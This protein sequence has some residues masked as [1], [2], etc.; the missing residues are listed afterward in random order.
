MTQPNI[1]IQGTVTG[2]FAGLSEKDIL[3]HIEGGE[4]VE[5]RRFRSREGDG[6][7]P[8]VLVTFKETQLPGRVF[9][10]AMAFQV[11]EYI[12]PPLRCYNC[13]RYGHIA[14]ACRGKKKCA[15][16]GGEHE[17]KECKADAPKCPNCGGDHKAAYWGCEHTKKARKVQEV[18]ERDKVTYAE[19]VRK[20]TRECV[21]K[22]RGRGPPTGNM[23]AEPS[24]C[25]TVP[26]DMLIMSKESFLSFVVEVLAA[27][28][29]VFARETS[30]NSD[31]VREVVGAADRFLG[32]KQVPEELHE[33]FSEGRRREQRQREQHD[34]E[35]DITDDVES[36]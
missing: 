12:R 32:V 11:R 4:V 13:Q 36:D 14:D 10:G 18:K 33:Y 24:K 8:P 25:P 5:V 20:V 22:E 29:K 9:L 27:A 19:A 30:N 35:E 28:K 6:R 16:C 15:K 23:R 31:L 2:L 1:T 21:V 26:P 7:D 34:G 17:I 3:E